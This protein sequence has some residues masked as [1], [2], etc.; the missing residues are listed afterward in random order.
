MASRQTESETLSE[1]SMRI[2][3]AARR[4]GVTTRTLRYWEEIG[5]LS[6][7]GREGRAGSE[8]LYMAADLARASRIKELQDLLGFSLCEIK[9]VLEADDV[10]EALRA[11]AQASAEPKVQLALLDDAIE[12]NA[13]LL[14]RVDTTLNRVQAFRTDR[15]EKARRMRAYRKKLL[16]QLQQGNLAEAPLGSGVK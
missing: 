3:E 16:A 15:F 1:G 7:K 12:A 9:A 2:G 6:P 11:A 8:R 13:R 4:S 10:V 5:L 14:A